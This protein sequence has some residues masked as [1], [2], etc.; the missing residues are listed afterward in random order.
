MDFVLNKRTGYIHRV[1][2][3]F[4]VCGKD[5]PVKHKMCAEPPAGAKFCSKCF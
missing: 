1:D 3:I 5:M 4:L 2:G